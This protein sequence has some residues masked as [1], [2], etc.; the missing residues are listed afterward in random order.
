MTNDDIQRSGY[1][2]FIEEEFFRVIPSWIKFQDEFTFPELFLN[3]MKKIIWPEG[4]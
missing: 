4:P 1:K 3:P 2:S